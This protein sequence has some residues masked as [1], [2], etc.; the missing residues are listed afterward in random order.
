M[1]V[2]C[3]LN[4]IIIDVDY[5]IAGKFQK[6]FGYLYSELQDNKSVRQENGKIMYGDNNGWRVL[7]YLD[8]NYRIPSMTSEITVLSYEEMTSDESCMTRSIPN[9]IE[10]TWS[11]GDK[12]MEY[13]KQGVYQY[14]KI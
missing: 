8:L 11:S 6:E 4:D 13:Y 7:G 3:P 1:I 5:F 14:S 12:R 2:Y 9:I 10:R